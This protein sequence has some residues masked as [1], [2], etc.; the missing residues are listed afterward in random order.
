M[1]TYQIIYIAIAIV[2]TGLV[3]FFDLRY[4]MLRDQPADPTTPKPKGGWSYSYA[5]VQLAWWSI[6]ILSA[7]IIIL[8]KCCV[9][10]ELQANVLLLLGISGGTTLSAKLIDVSDI[11]NNKNRNISKD[12]FILDILSDSTGVS[13]HRL[14]AVIINVAVGAWFFISVYKNINS[15]IVTCKDIIPNITDQVMILLGIGTGTY[16]AL[17][18]TE[19]KTAANAGNNPQQGAG[20]NNQ[21]QGGG[22]GGA[23]QG[24]A[25]NNQQ[26]DAGN[27]QQAGQ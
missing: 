13:V 5:R 19:N 6:I 15:S 4:S 20:N 12:G 25:N 27:N 16:V 8:C 11:S 1:S 9:A 24:G 26:P 21:P 7:F 3:V 17:K 23:Q 10:P 18:T 22:N 2:L 14:Q